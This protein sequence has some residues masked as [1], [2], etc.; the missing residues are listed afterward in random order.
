MSKVNRTKPISKDHVKLAD[1]QPKIVAKDNLQKKLAKYLDYISGIIF[2]VAFL[3]AKMQHIPHPLI[4][5]VSKFVGL[6]GYL[7]GYF[8]WY[9]STLF[10]PKQARVENTWFGFAEFKDQFQATS[11]IGLVATVLCLV[12]PVL[13]LPATCLFAIS[14]ILWL[15]GEHH[16][17]NTPNIPGRNLSSAAKSHYFIYVTLITAVSVMIAIG[18]TIAFFCPVIAPPILMATTIMSIGLSLVAMLF[19]LRSN[20]ASKPAEE[21][22][23]IPGESDRKIEDENQAVLS[24]SAQNQVENQHF[25]NPAHLEFG[26]NKPKFC[27]NHPERSE[28]SPEFATALTSGDPSL[29]SG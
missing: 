11:L 4:S 17:N 2:F 1:G 15:I 21:T 12:F 18:M 5:S 14:N 16:K 26:A 7:L 28:G 24:L 27:L 3:V 22:R 19:L 6:C 10:Y 29:R 8:S 25:P 23:V 20:C 13:I 9:L